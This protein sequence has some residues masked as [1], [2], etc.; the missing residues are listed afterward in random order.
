MQESVLTQHRIRSAVLP[1]QGIAAVH[2]T[3]R[4]AGEIL[5]LQQGDQ[6]FL[7]SGFITQR[8]PDAAQMSFW[9]LKVFLQIQSA[10]I[11]RRVNNPQS[12]ATYSTAHPY[13]L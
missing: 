2:S 6:Q 7:C 3:H 4:S 13:N 12:V 5:S 9:E 8:K 10:P 11:Q 1:D